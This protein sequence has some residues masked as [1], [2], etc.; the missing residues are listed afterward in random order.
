[1]QLGSIF[2]VQ[3]IDNVNIRINYAFI[4]LAEGALHWYLNQLQAAE[5]AIL[6]DT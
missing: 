6:W 4:A 1:M 5:G 2:N 3:D